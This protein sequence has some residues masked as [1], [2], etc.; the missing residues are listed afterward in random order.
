MTSV[1]LELANCTTVEE[2]QE[3]LIE[4]NFDQLTAL[5]R[6]LGCGIDC[7]TEAVANYYCVKTK[8]RRVK[9][10]SNTG[11]QFRGV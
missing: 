7:L 5:S 3:R 2:I 11:N 10:E 1:I 8:K 4:M 9:N 6:E